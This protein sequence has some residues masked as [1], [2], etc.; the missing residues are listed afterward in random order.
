ML[1]PGPFK[2]V[3]AEFMVDHDMHREEML[4]DAA[5]ID[6][7]LAHKGPIIPVGTT[8]LRCLESLYW[9]GTLLHMQQNSDVIPEISQFTAY[10]TIETPKPH[11][12]LLTLQQFLSKSDRAVSA[13]TALMI[14]P[15]YRFRLSTALI[16]NF[17]Q[18]QSTL[19]LL[20]AAA[21]GEDWRRVYKHALNGP[22]R[23]LSY[24]DSSLLWI[25]PE[26]RV[27]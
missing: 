19:L 1:A 11:T 8:A 4:L 26:N 9:L 17:H 10:D 6:R 14:A 15:G 27:L 5:L 21:I 24:G 13:F 7:L 23:F 16:T 3:K 2:P 12:A 20:V 25:K 18:P 22:Y